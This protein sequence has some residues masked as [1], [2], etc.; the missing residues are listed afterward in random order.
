MIF[1]FEGRPTDSPLVERI[2]RTTS[3]EQTPVSFISTAASNW[4][5]VIMRQ[6]G[7][8]ILTV[9]GPET[10]ASDAPIPENAEFFGISFKLGVFMPH[11]PVN[12]L[13]DVGINLPEAGDNSFWFNGSVWQ[14]PN[15]ENS[16]VFVDRLVRQGILVREPIVDAALQGKLPDVSLRS[17]QRRFLRATGLTHGTI[18]QIERARRALALLEQ[19]MP[20]MDT[21]EIAGY[22]DQPH[23]TRMLKRFAGQ[24]PAQILR[25]NRSR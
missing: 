11:L 13:V 7:K 14:F 25:L 22:S 15:F 2:W 24:T 4:E 16:D 8:T 9:R 17:V 19:G 20:I 1:T 5:M 12:Q 6:Y 21:V 3:G 18:I 23:L 10:K